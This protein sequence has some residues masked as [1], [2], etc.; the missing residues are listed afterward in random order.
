MTLYIKDPAT[1]KAARAL[2]RERNVTVTEAVREAC[3]EALA[4]A[5][6]LR[7][8]A[9]RLAP[10]FATLDPLPRNGPALDKAFFDSEWDDAQ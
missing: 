5:K 3:E 8:L 10:L 7:P 9:D 4:R 6:K 2:A 1:D